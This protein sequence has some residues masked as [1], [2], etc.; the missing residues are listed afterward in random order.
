MKG[1]KEKEK[2]TETAVV[3][4]APLRLWVGEQYLGV[5]PPSLFIYTAHRMNA[6]LYKRMGKESR[7]QKQANA[8]RLLVQAVEKIARRGIASS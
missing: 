1:E 7:A 8:N 2:E 6:E 5:L 3:G 4:N